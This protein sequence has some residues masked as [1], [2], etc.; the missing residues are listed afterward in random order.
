MAA[1][2]D[3]I[4]AISLPSLALQ[5]TRALSGGVASDSTQSDSWTYY[6]ITRNRAAECTIGG[7]EPIRTDFC[8]YV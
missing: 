2:Q 8:L 5:A 6:T 7:Q 4:V 3:T 1:T